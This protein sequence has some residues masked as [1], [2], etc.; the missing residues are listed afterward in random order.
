MLPVA[1][2]QSTDGHRQLAQSLHESGFAVISGHGIPAN[3]LAAFYENWN[4]FFLESDKT[5]F[6]ADP[7]THA[8]YFSLEN[9]ETA[10]S[11]AA[12]D[13]KEYYQFWPG[14]PLP[15]SQRQLTL[16]LYD[17]MYE[18]ATTVLAVLQRYSADTLWARLERPLA[19]Y[20][21]RPD[22]MMRILRYPPLTGSEPTQ[23]LRAAPHEDI[24]FITLLPA[25]TQS[26]LQI[27]PR[28]SD[29]QPVDTPDGAIIINIGDMLQEL[30]DHKLPSTT[31]RVINPKGIAGHQAR[32]SAPLFCHPEPSLRLSDQ[33]T[34]GA[35]LRERLNEINPKQM[36]DD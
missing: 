31:H 27:K 19:D 2:L 10:K 11:A 24:N 29:W 22:T 8:G 1:D 16:Q 17:L 9:A 36:G 28:K 18:L 4:N 26:G 13:I 5:T 33:Y 14:G 6:K 30:T 25:A 35:Y 21:S 34:A 20:L 3:Q 32:V 12:Q 23:A 7:A 15:D